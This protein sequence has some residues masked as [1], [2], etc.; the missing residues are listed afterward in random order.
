MISIK[1]KPDLRK[2]EKKKMEFISF[3]LPSLEILIIISILLSLAVCVI[4]LLNYEQIPTQMGV[5]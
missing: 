4:Y 3:R 5:N 2:K 1:K